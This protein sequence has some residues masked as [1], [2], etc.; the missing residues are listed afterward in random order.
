MGKKKG[1]KGETLDKNRKKT[2]KPKLINSPGCRDEKNIFF[3]FFLLSF[4]SSFFFSL[5]EVKL[6]GGG[7]IIN[8]ATPSS[9]PTIGIS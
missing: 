9:Y 2:I 6:V 8:G 4:F 3:V 5:K 7:S 1:E